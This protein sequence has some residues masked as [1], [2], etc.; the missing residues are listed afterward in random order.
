MANTFKFGNKQWYGKKGSVLAYNDENNNFKPLPFDFTRSSSATRVNKDGLIEVVGS[1]E[2]RVDYLNNAD[3]HLLLE[4]SRTN[5]VTYSEDFSLWAKTRATITSN[6]EIS[7]DGLSN[8]SALVATA[9]NDDHFINITPVATNA[10]H[11]YSVFLK[12]GGKNWARLWETTTNVYVD[13]NLDTG[14][15]GSSSGTIIDNGTEYYG[16]GWYR[17]YITYNTGSAG[18]KVCRIYSLEGDGDRSYL[19]DGITEEIYIYG[20]QFEE[21][22]Y[23]TSYIPT[24][25]SSVTR[26]SEDNMTQ[27]NTKAWDIT[28]SFSM[29]FSFGNN[30]KAGGSSPVL[31]VNTSGNRFQ[32]YTNAAGNGGLNIYLDGQGGYIFGASGNDAMN[33]DQSKVCITYNASTGRLAYFIN[34]SLW[35]EQT[36]ALSFGSFTNVVMGNAGETTLLSIKDN[37]LYT[38]ALTDSEAIALTS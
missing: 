25:G 13:F 34:G 1:D 7:P 33:A 30:R 20:A 24:S 17:C 5:L 6:A 27:V 2:P 9:V 28:S 36:S 26:A 37:K 10:I 22:S 21:G 14:G 3:G 8:A 18:S 19:G 23:A 11:T 16:N 4:P 15:T 32:L 31:T 38:N 35:N 29:Y 12:K